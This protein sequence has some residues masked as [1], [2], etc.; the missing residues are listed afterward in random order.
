MWRNAPY[1]SVCYR[2]PRMIIH[3]MR[4]P[5]V[6]RTIRQLG[7]TRTC[8]MWRKALWRS[9]FIR[10]SYI[11]VRILRVPTL[12]SVKLSFDIAR[13][14]VASNIHS[15]TSTTSLVV[16]T[17]IVPVV[18][19]VLASTPTHPTLITPTIIPPTFLLGSSPAILLLQLL[20]LAPFPLVVATT[21]TTGSRTWLLPPPLIH[22]PLQH[23]SRP[24]SSLMFSLDMLIRIQR[25]RYKSNSCS[26]LG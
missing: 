8:T 25:M 22:R 10:R 11:V 20:R 12:R 7:I 16:F 1:R 2:C 23:P 14:M 9:V 24:M 13:R 19:A 26:F 5:P 4:R 18:I 3:C 17:S 6:R 15:F 21:T